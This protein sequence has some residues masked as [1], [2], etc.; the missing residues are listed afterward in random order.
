[1]GDQDNTKERLLDVAER[2]FAERGYA[3]TSLRAMTR[4]AG[5]NLGAVNYHFGSKEGLYAA[6][7]AR[8]V[9]PVVR[10]RLLLL[11]ACEQTAG[12]GP[13]PVEE[14]ARAF[15]APLFGSGRAQSLRD[16]TF[17][18]LLGRLHDDPVESLRHV[19][20]QLLRES[21]VR[22]V[23]VL[24]RS[25]PGVPRA[26]LLWRLHFVRAMV[27][28]TVLLGPSLRACTDG[29]C[30]PDDV[31]AVVERLVGFAVAGLSAPPAVARPAAAP[32]RGLP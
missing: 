22:F 10:E 14:V 9:E 31:A 12:G 26:E 23:A 30:D 4:S 16:A 3:A 5:V 19:Y 1:M 27:N 13:V 18:R 17:L 20:D 15:V 25:L 8:R 21:V 29:L 28:Q 2:L 6:V 11:A 32:G 7:F 24:E